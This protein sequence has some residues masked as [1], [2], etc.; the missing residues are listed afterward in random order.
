MLNPANRITDRAYELLLERYGDD[1]TVFACADAVGNL[2]WLCLMREI[3]PD[4]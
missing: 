2:R 3:D 1:K 4:A